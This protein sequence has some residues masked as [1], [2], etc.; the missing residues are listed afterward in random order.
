MTDNQYQDYFKSIHGL[1]NNSSSVDPEYTNPYTSGSLP[2]SFKSNDPY[3]NFQQGRREAA[4]DASGLF[5]LQSGVLPDEDKMYKMLLGTSGLSPMSDMISSL[6][7]SKKQ[8]ID[9][10]KIKSALVGMPKSAEASIPPESDRVE[11]TDSIK[12]GIDH[13][14]NNK[15]TEAIDSWKKALNEFP[16]KKD[17][18]NSFIK[19]ASDE[20]NAYTMFLKRQQ[21]RDQSADRPY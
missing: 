15:W 3:G 2:A 4:N 11:K 21:E 10:D 5:K 9:F 6:S 16:D 12:T 13:Y 7:K 19:R 1:N 20:Q 8:S 18:I 17:Q 14:T